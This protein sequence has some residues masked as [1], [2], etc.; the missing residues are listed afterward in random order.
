MPCP[1]P[2]RSPTSFLTSA[3]RSG[4][5]LLPEASDSFVASA[6][7]PVNAGNLVALDAIANAEARIQF[8]KIMGYDQSHRA[9]FGLISVLK[10]PTK[11][12]S[13]I[14]KTPLNDAR[15]GRPRKTVS[16]CCPA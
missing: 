13:C 8:K 4:K 14:S 5:L 11:K 15:R 2:K 3:K 9:G 7:V 16:A 1:I 10:I 6:S 12:L